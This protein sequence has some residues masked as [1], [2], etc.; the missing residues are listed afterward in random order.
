M[1]VTTKEEL[2]TLLG[3]D[4]TFVFKGTEPFTTVEHSKHPLGVL[5][6]KNGKVL[7]FECDKWFKSIGLHAHTHG[8]TANQYKEKYGFDQASGL[9][10]VAISRAHSLRATANLKNGAYHGFQAG[11]S[12]GNRPSSPIK[13]SMQARNR[14]GICP[15]QIKYRLQLL[16]AKV[17]MSPSVSDANKHDRGLYPATVHHYGGWNEAKRALGLETYTG[18]TSCKTTCT[19]NIA[20]LIYDLRAYIDEYHTLP[21]IANQRQNNFPHSMT[22]YMGHWGSVR[23]AWQHCGIKKVRVM[24]Q[25][26]KYHWITIS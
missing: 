3:E 21:W 23:K 15:E 13:H 2:K 5:I 7:C 19:K 16:A 4:I 18:G 6:E 8:M 10:S 11:N 24:C 22:V 20:D 25:G 12:L 17:G 1:S 26:C 14:R 9:C